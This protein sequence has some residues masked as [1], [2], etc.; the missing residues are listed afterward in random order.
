LYGSSRSGLDAARHGVMCDAVRSGST[1]TPVSA[2]RPPHTP[3]RPSRNRPCQSRARRT[4]SHSVG[5]AIAARSFAQRDRSSSAPSSW[6][7]WN[8]NAL[9]RSRRGVMPLRVTAE[10][11]RYLGWCCVTNDYGLGASR[12]ATSPGGMWCLNSASILHHTVQYPCYAVRHGGL[13]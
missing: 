11:L 4:S 7:K 13:S 6:A 1:S 12:L 9:G 5:T 8:T 3:I 10:S 2:H